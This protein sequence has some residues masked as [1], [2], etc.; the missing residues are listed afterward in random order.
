MR[1]NKLVL[2]TKANEPGGMLPYIVMTE[3]E[4]GIEDML[5]RFQ[6]PGDANAFA[7][8]IHRR[9]TANGIIADLKIW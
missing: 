4:Q 6:A 7:I 8:E 9:Y 5:A 3:D 1:K 2:V